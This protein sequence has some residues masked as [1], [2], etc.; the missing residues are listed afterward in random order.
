MM[1][2]TMRSLILGVAA[3]AMLACPARAAFVTVDDFSEIILWAGTGVNEA[4][5]VLQFTDGE[6]PTSIAWGYRWDGSATA[7]EMIFAIAGSITGAAPAPPAGL[8]SRL[9]IDVSEFAPFGFFVNTISYNQS[10]L[11]SE[12]FQGTRQIVDDFVNTGTYPAFYL[13]SAA[14][15]VWSGA[16]MNL[17][18]SGA[19]MSDTVLADG[20][21]YGFVQSD[22]TDP[23]AFTQPVS[24]VPEPGTWALAAGAAVAGLVIWRRARGTR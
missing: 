5:F 6:A 2:K 16:T 12:W 19:G 11:P 7:E 17:D 13:A 21:W 14:G 24:A 10:G 8:D 9:A 22:G 1:M 23:F 3:A 15:G 20:G 4:G 18:L